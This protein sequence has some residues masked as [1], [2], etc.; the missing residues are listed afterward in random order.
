MS[1]MNAKKP[2]PGPR[3]GGDWSWT[4]SAIVRAGLIAQRMRVTSRAQDEEQNQRITW[5]TTMMFREI[6]PSEG[7]EMEGTQS[8]S[9]VL[10][11]AGV[12][13]L[14]GPVV[15]VSL[16]CVPASC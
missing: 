7:G 6:A 1:I 3:R 13:K 9:D 8:D 5:P 11:A 16:H 4:G 12:A 15:S 2:V 10:N 14:A